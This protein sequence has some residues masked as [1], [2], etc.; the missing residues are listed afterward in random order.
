MY[1]YLYDYYDYSM[2]E[3][4]FWLIN[5]WNPK[6]ILSYDFF[7]KIRSFDNMLVNLRLIAAPQYPYFC[8]YLKIGF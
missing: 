7:Y 1:Y 6:P 2:I 3:H 5:N 4:T 8:F